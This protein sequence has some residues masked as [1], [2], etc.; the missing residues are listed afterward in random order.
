[1]LERGYR[2]EWDG[3][4]AELLSIGDRRYVSLGTLQALGWKLSRSGTEWTAQAA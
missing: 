3:G 1:M 4:G 2:L